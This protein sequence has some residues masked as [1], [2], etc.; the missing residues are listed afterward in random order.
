MGEWRSQLCEDWW[1]GTMAIEKKQNRLEQTVK[2]A[3]GAARRAGSKVSWLF[4][5]WA[6]LGEAKVWWHEGPV[7]A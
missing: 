1:N 7:T 6:N 3:R 4:P 5:G 2:R